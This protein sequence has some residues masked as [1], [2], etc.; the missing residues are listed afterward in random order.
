MDRPNMTLPYTQQLLY[1]AVAKA[2]KMS[3]AKLILVIVSEGG[4]EQQALRKHQ[5]HTLRFD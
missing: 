4:R 3:G 2:V 1:V 5:H